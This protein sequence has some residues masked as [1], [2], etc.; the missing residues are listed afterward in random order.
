MAQALHFTTVGIPPEQGLR[1]YQTAVNLHEITIDDPAVFAVEAWAWRVG[2]MVLTRSRVS[3]MR[4]TRSVQQIR[5][6][7]VDHYSIT[8][9]QFGSSWGTAGARPFRADADNVVFLDLAQPVD[10]ANEPSEVIILMFPRDWL[11]EIMEPFDMHGLTVP[12]AFGQI[13][14]DYL[15][16]LTSNAASLEASEDETVARATRHLIAAC[17]SSLRSSDV[18]AP[19]PAGVLAKAKRV[20]AERLANDLNTEDIAQA[21]GASRTSL[22]R[23]FE[24]LGG[25]QTYIRRRRLSLAHVMLSDARET[26]SLSEIA[27]CAGFASSSSLS[28]H[29]R[30][31]YG[32]T[33]SAVRGGVRRLA[34]RPTEVAKIPE[35]TFAAWKRSMRH[36]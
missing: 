27:F 8:S 29:F 14:N 34:Q 9:C 13:L 6:D 24:P 22:Y 33:P 3:D 23:A 31:Q 17:V 15:V 32:Y 4:L 35:M 7:G 30:A 11:D 36:E 16:S 5:A 19:R 10:I 25:V 21:V 2:P 20:I 18:A 1:A 12:G 26:R 28:R